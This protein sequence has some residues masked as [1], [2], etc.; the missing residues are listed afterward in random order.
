MAY[1]LLNEVIYTTFLGTVDEDNLSTIAIITSLPLPSYYCQLRL[2]IKCEIVSVHSVL[3]GT[4]C[5]DVTSSWTS[6][7][8]S[9]LTQL[10]D[11]GATRRR[12]RSLTTWEASHRTIRHRCYPFVASEDRRWRHIFCSRKPRI[13]NT[14]CHETLAKRSYAFFSRKGWVSGDFAINITLEIK[15]PRLDRKWVTEWKGYPYHIPRVSSSAIN[16][17]RTMRTLTEWWCAW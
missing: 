5:L 16:R 17:G 3:G 6:Y 7:W 9:S 2:C 15:E 11:D 8:M 1:R 13:V 4:N 14:I 10:L 12:H